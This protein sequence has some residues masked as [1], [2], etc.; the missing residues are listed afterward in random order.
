MSKQKPTDILASI[1]DMLTPLSSDERKRIIQAALTLMGDTPLGPSTSAAENGD[2]ENDAPS[3]IPT[4]GRTWLRQNG[5]SGEMLDQVFH[6]NGGEMELI[7]SEIPGKSDKER[8]LNV[9]ILAG[10]ARLLGTGSSAFE[11]KYAR[12]LCAD[13]GCYDPTNHATRLKS[14]GNELSGSKDKGWTLTAPGL[15]KGA[16]L[17]KEMSQ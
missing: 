13:A 6:A 15:K 10:I 9:Y 3:D 4:K 7:A 16:A 14:K 8:T 1:V 11:D 17:V 2:P 12:E 5:I